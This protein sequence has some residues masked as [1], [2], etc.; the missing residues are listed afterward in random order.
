MIASDDNNPNFTG[1]HDPDARL[2]C[3]FYK[4]AIPNE[5]ES[6]K[7]GRPCFDEVDFVQIKIPGNQLNDVDD[8][9][10]E[11]HKQR[12]PRQ[13]AIYQ[14]ANATGSQMI[15]TPVEQWPMISRSVAEELKASKFPTV[16]S[17]AHASDQQLQSIGMRAGMNPH[18]F[19]ER[20]QN[21]LKR[22]ESDAQAEKTAQE[23]AELAEKLDASNRAIEEMRAQMV[24]LM[25]NQRAKPGRKPATE[26]A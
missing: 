24:E 25:A 7:H 6:K 11:S 16:E 9:V 3:R 15:G 22:A 20:A 5:F 13:W 14:N 8:F 1:A 23:K 10:N 17:I 2:Y 12:F 19:R 26:E 18:T 21:W 4:K